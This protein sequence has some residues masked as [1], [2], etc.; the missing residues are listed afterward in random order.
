MITDITPEPECRHIYGLKDTGFDYF[1]IVI[2]PKYE[3]IHT[4]QYQDK[5]FTYCPLCGL[6]LVDKETT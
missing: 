4:F 3:F 2:K 6:K 1:N 5:E